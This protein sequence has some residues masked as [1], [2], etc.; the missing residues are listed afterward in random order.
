MAFFYVVEY[1]TG[2]MHPSVH[3]V[4]FFSCRIWY[5]PDAP[6]RWFHLNDSSLSSR[7]SVLHLTSTVSCAKP[8]PRDSHSLPLFHRQRSIRAVMIS[9]DQRVS[10]LSLDY[11]HRIYLSINLGKWFTAACWSVSFDSNQNM[12]EI[13][14][15]SLVLFS[16]EPLRD[17]RPTCVFNPF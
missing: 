11:C 6:K 8:L 9:N 10:K 13:L 17:R 5:W 14:F 16:N 12:C 1:D 3:A 4:V 2:R 15:L 7:I